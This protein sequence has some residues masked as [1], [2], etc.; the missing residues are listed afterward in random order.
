[1]DIVSHGGYFYH[2]S[3]VPTIVATSFI[4]HYSF[5][6]MIVVYVAL[7]LVAAMP[8]RAVLLTVEFHVSVHIR[9]LL[10]KVTLLYIMRYL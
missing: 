2:L 8:I 7:C 4:A 1:M 10:S 5:L 9:M 6:Y 3:R